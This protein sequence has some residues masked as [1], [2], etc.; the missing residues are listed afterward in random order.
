MKIRVINNTS[1]QYNLIVDELPMVPTFIPPEAF[2]NEVIRFIKR[3]PIDLIQIGSPLNFF[4]LTKR[5]AWNN[6]YDLNIINIRDF[7]L[8]APW[9]LELKQIQLFFLDSEKKSH[10]KLFDSLTAT[11]NN[12][13]FYYFYGKESAPKHH[14]IIESPEDFISK[15][16]FQQEQLFQEMNIQ[17]LKI[18]LDM[19]I[20]Y[21]DF[22][23]N[24]FFL[25][26]DGNYRIINNLIG[27]FGETLFQEDN[28]EIKKKFFEEFQKANT[29]KDSFERQNRFIPQ[30]K[31]IDR[32]TMLCYEKDLV[33]KVSPIETI[34][35]PLIL[36]LPFHNPD[37]RKIYNDADVIKTIQVEQTSNY[38]HVV[39]PKQDIPHEMYTTGMHIIKHRIDYLDDVAFLHASFSFSPMIRFP[40]KGKSIYRELSFFRTKAFPNMMV[41]KNRKKLKQTIY[42]FGKALK[43]QVLSQELGNLIKNRNGQII[44]IS[45]L[46]IEW[47]LINEIPFSF[48]H[49]IARLPETSLHGLIS[50]YTNNNISRYSIP[51]NV[52]EKTLVIMGTEEEAFK[53]W[54][55]QV[56]EL[57]RTKKFVIRRCKTVEEVKNSVDEIRPD[58][59]IFDCHGGYDKNTRSTYLC[60][61]D[62]KLDGNYVVEN[63]IF[64]PIIF[65]S[66]CGT[67]PTYGTINPIAN[68]FFEVGA[69]SVTSTYLPIS[70]NSGS[71]L[72]LR[73][74]NNL[75]FAANNVIHKNWLE[76]VC[77]LIRSSSVNDAYKGAWFKLKGSEKAG[78]NES[79]THS[80]TQLL[81]FSERPNVYKQL[82]ET[83]VRGTKDKKDYF[84]EIIPE[85]LLYSNLGRGDLILFEN[86]EKAHKEK[87][88]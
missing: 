88:L 13:F 86:W 69:I 29:K 14:R 83:I 24:F 35:A 74:L 18:N 8:I 76:F 56:F 58:I 6:G 82:N 3:C 51:E 85:Y 43:R 84:A 79:N 63:K 80:L 64:A 37:L 71:V 62:E 87:N 49:D 55:D 27:N 23:E 67:A 57:S 15:I 78:L 72:Y 39:D 46:P 4:E 38:L 21:K 45:D 53:I 5:L 9:V 47:L 25:P 22:N 10:H 68:A 42:K 20:A 66:A 59:L 31:K 12:L 60:M 54:Q 50:F 61:G 11:S 28:A 48:T 17:D 41:S 52:M 65:L 73:L 75:E 44:C 7:E 40:M 36:I 70:V 34:L 1:I 81:Q 19:E 30:I 26:T 2:M 77:H 33:E 32:F 16:I